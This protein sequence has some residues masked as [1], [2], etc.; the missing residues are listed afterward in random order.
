MRLSSK[1][2][3][4]TNLCD[5]ALYLVALKMSQRRFGPTAP[6]ISVT[7]LENVVGVLIEV[8]IEGKRVAAQCQ[9]DSGLDWHYGEVSMTIEDALDVISDQFHV[10]V[11]K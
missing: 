4:R 7:R 8:S 5:A 9:F 1:V 2:I 6:E 11:A 3:G 10:P